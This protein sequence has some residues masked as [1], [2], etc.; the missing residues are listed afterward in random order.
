MS[1]LSYGGAPGKDECQGPPT[2]SFQE[3]PNKKKINFLTLLVQKIYIFISTMTK[4]NLSPI[5]IHIFRT[6]KARMLNFFLF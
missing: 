6:N 1:V 3:L 4:H 5:K 2:S